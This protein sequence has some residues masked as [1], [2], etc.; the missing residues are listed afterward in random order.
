[1]GKHFINWYLNGTQPAVTEDNVVFWYRSHW[2]NDAC[3]QGLRCVP[4]SPIM[5]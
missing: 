3:T 2:K 1:M 4:I 5:P